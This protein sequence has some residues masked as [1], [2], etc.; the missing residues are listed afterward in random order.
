MTVR[1]ALEANYCSKNINIVILELVFIFPTIV[2]QIQSL[3][4]KNK[5]FIRTL[6][7]TG[8]LCGVDPSEMWSVLTL[9]AELKF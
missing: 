8:E 7:F 2:L 9:K 3:T 6:P 5:Y 1:T 4:S